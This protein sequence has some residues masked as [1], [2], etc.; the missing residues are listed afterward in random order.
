MIQ[1]LL[2]GLMIGSV[3]PTKAHGHGDGGGY[4]NILEILKEE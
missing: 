4:L 1:D 3:P 2:V